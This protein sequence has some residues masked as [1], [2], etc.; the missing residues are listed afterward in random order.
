MRTDTN[1]RI[2]VDTPLR[3]PMHDAMIQRQCL[4]R[5]LVHAGAAVLT[6]M[7]GFRVV[8]VQTSKRT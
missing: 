4:S 5:T 8:T 6:H 3:V 7:N 1:T 2:A